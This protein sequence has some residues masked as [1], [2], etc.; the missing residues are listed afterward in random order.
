MS[1]LSSFILSSFYQLQGLYPVNVI[2]HAY[3]GLLKVQYKKSCY[4]SN[5]GRGQCLN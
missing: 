2:G 3:V 1:L 5:V 4:S